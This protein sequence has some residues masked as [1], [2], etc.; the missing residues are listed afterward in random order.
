MVWIFNQDKGI[1]ARDYLNKELKEGRLRQGWGFDSSLKLDYNNKN[2]W[3]KRV[4]D[5]TEYSMEESEK[6][7]NILKRLKVIKPD[8]LILVLHC[9]DPDSFSI[10]EAIDVKQQ[11]YDFILDEKVGDYGHII[12]INKNTIKEFENSLLPSKNFNSSYRDCIQY[13]GINEYEKK[14]FD[15]TGKENRFHQKTV[16]AMWIKLGNDDIP[17]SEEQAI[18][19]CIDE[20]IIAIGWSDFFGDRKDLTVKEAKLLVNK[21][22][23]VTNKDKNKILRFIEE[24]GIGDLIIFYNKFTCKYYFGV[25]K[26]ERIVYYGDSNLDIGFTRKLSQLKEIDKEKIPGDILR[27]IHTP[28]TQKNTNNSL[29]D[30]YFLKKISN[31]K[32]IHSKDLNEQIRSLKY[33]IFRMLNPLELEDIVINYLQKIEGWSVLK[34]SC[35]ASNRTF[36][37]DLFKL[38][39]KNKRMGHVTVKSGYQQIEPQEI[40]EIEKVN[41]DEEVYIFVDLGNIENIKHLEDKENVHFIKHKELLEYIEE[42]SCELTDSVKSKLTII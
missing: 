12:H 8:D 7:L 15:L 36:E 11:I 17:D 24:I 2:Q 4:T 1:L 5:S 41:D 35:S 29:F 20:N 27:R 26:D 32:R 30:Y 3:I 40:K 10:V 37:C 19:K 39:N 21:S 38:E 18:T 16:W 42:Y 23:N 34:S 6:R 25:V 9:P 28:Q 31:S 14:I 13:L 22:R 33:S